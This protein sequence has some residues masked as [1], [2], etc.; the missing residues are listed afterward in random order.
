MSNNHFRFK[1]AKRRNVRN[2]SLVQRR[3]KATRQAEGLIYVLGMV[4]GLVMVVVNNF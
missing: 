2:G 4:L 3:S 1:P